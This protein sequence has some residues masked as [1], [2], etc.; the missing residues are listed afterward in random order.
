MAK[1][2]SLLERMRDNP[3]G[4]WQHADAEK[5]CREV[6]LQIEAPSRGS[7]FKVYSLHFDEPLTVPAHRPIKPVYI[8]LPVDW[9]QRHL[10]LGKEGNKND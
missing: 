9:A 6:G 3:R 1:K 2:R 8:R 4:D 7:H 5:L 10:D